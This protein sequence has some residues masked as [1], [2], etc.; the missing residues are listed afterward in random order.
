MWRRN[1]SSEANCVIII[2]ISKGCHRS[3]SHEVCPIS[4]NSC[5]SLICEMPWLAALAMLSF[6]AGRHCCYT[7]S[8]LQLD[9]S[10]FYPSSLYGDSSLVTVTVPYTESSLYKYTSIH[11]CSHISWAF[12]K[13]IPNSIF[14]LIN[15]TVII[16]KMS[17]G[18]L[19]AGQRYRKPK[20]KF[21]MLYVPISST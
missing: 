13:W 1:S 3:G 11:N 20:I 4:R 7:M 18:I 10:R 16:L 15:E 9:F 19:L 5:V 17:L 6:A 8:T 2:C 14:L 12:I 21:R